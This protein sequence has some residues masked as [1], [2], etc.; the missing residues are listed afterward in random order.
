MKKDIIISGT[1]KL[2]ERGNV[3]LGVEWRRE[4]RERIERYISYFGVKGVV[5]FD[6]QEEVTILP[7]NSY[8]TSIGTKI[9][10]FPEEASKKTVDDLK[11]IITK[12]FES[13]SDGYRLTIVFHDGEKVKT[14]WSR[15]W[16]T[17]RKLEEELNMDRIREGWLY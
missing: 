16:R 4:T 14:S 2:Y 7:N 5:T 13:E 3:E 17:E 8:L 10:L 9:E 1:S 12:T 15:N 11:D 6:D